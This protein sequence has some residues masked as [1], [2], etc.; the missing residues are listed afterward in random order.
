LTG[1]EDAPAVKAIDGVVGLYRQAL[2]QIQPVEP[3]IYNELMI[4]AL[5]SA[6]F[7]PVGK[8]YHV[9]L[10]ITDGDV[11]DMRETIDSIVEAS[12]NQPLS[13]IIVGVGPSDFVK[14]EV[15]DADL[16]PLIDSDGRQA[17]R[18]IV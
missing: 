13:V 7:T 9:L 15:L 18:D 3:T 10:L 11:H 12:I 8:V 14:M 5:M 4:K 16:N 17:A 6:A 2:P 1:R